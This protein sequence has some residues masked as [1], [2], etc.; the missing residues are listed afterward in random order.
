MPRPNKGKRNRGA[1]SKVSPA[2]RLNH[3]DM[4]MLL[5][6][7]QAQT[8][9][10]VPE[11]PDVPRIRLNPVQIYNAMLSYSS[12]I[13]VSTTAP[14][15]GGI[16]FALNQVGNYASYTSC[17]DKFRIMQVN[18]KFI[19]NTSPGTGSI[20]YT[21]FDYDDISPLA[22]LSSI[23]G[24][25]NV[26]I[27]PAGTIEDRTLNPKFA[28]ATYTGSAFNGYSDGN[29]MAWI[30]AASNNAQYYGLKY[31]LPTGTSPQTFTVIVTLFLQFKNQRAS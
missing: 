4:K 17:F 31:Y 28:V 29:P 8:I 2:G 30:D 18:V 14:T 25:N 27:A 3:E 5:Q 10:F 7:A 23:L 6:V 22:G 12:T 26:K 19:P 24:Y 13:V 21:C 15:L 16:S 9:K 20:L 1:R 11:V